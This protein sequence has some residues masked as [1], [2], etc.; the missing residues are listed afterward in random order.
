MY[1]FSVFF[2]QKI[3][4]MNYGTVGTFRALPNNR[5]ILLR[6]MDVVKTCIGLANFF[7]S[8]SLKLCIKVSN[9]YRCAFRH[10]DASMNALWYIHFLSSIEIHQLKVA[11]LVLSEYERGKSAKKRERF[12]VSKVEFRV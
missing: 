1:R 12:L 2:S 3:F 5:A 11:S 10:I 6:V 7:F 4:D 9:D 8:G